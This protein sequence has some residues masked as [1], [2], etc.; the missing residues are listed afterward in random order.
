MK[1]FLKIALSF[2]CILLGFALAAIITTVAWNDRIEDK[3]YHCVDMGFLGPWD[4]MDTHKK[5]GDILLPG[6]TWEQLKL[7]RSHYI[8]A[9]WTLWL[10]MAGALVGAYFCGQ[11][12]HQKSVP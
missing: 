5:G 7:A 1:L 11:K 3:A 4:D 8:E 9:F 12:R 2:G 6:W 10:V